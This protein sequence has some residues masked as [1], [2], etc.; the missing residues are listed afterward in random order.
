MKRLWSAGVG[1]W[2]SNTGESHGS[3]ATRASC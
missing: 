2:R 3:N 1:A